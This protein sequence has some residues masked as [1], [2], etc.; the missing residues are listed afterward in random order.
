MALVDDSQDDPSTQMQDDP[1][2]EMEDDPSDETEDDT[3]VVVDN[4]KA[5]LAT[6]DE[7]GEFKHP[8]SMDVDCLNVSFDD[9]VSAA[10]DSQIKLHSK[11]LLVIIIPEKA[12]SE[13]GYMRCVH[14]NNSAS[15]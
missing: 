3:A 15:M 4:P 8:F 10:K 12:H 9:I 2:A 11:R 13:E 7:S 5:D 6:K 1:S 14:Q